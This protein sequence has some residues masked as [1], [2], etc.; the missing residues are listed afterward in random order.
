M[1]NKFKVTLKIYYIFKF[2]HG[3]RLPFSSM[4]II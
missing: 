4:Q 1:F 3:F 2:D